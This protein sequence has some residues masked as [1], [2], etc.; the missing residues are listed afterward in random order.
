MVHSGM[1]SANWRWSL[2]RPRLA[3]KHSFKEKLILFIS[4]LP[5]FSLLLFSFPFLFQ[6]IVCLS[7]WQLRVTLSG[8]V[9]SGKAKR[10]GLLPFSLSLSLILP[11]LVHSC[12]PLA[13]VIPLC[14]YFQL[15]FDDFY[16]WLNVLRRACALPLYHPFRHRHFTIPLDLGFYS[17]F[18]LPLPLLVF[19]PLRAP[20]NQ[21]CSLYSLSHFLNAVP[22]VCAIFA[23]GALLHYRYTTEVE[24]VRR[25]W[26]AVISYAIRCVFDHTVQYRYVLL[27]RLIN[28]PIIAQWLVTKHNYYFSFSMGKSLYH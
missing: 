20:D 1:F 3:I 2:W 27:R 11:L 9:V 8:W 6:S 18:S 12:Y 10:G 25:H 15:D 4:L 23:V 5:L 13:I 21:N 24:L 28:H 19:L 22:C 7:L 17:S 26:P 16:Y 14:N